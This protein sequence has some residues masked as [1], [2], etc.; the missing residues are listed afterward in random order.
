MLYFC[1]YPGWSRITQSAT[2]MSVRV[3]P[4]DQAS[5]PVKNWLVVDKVH[6]RIRNVMD[7]RD[8]CPLL[9]RHVFHDAGGDELRRGH[10]GAL[11]GHGLQL[12]VAE[13]SH[14]HFM[15]LRNYGHRCCVLR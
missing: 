8:R 12:S 3:F 7:P 15:L 5:Y 4:G 9:L 6:H 10:D 14:I 11:G 13:K 1:L 2:V